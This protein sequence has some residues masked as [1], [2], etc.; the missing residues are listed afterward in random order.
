[1]EGTW[2]RKGQGYGRDMIMEG[3][4]VWRGQW[5]ERDMG[6]EGTWGMEREQ[7]TEGT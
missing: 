6:M 7:G 2:V 4:R 5:Y 3:T 1:M